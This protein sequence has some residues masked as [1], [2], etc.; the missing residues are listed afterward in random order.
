[1]PRSATPTPER[2]EV[3]VNETL[4]A[5]DMAAVAQLSALQAGYAEDRDLVNQLLGQAQMAD[6]FAK[7]SLTVSTSK[8]AH[9]KENKLYRAMKGQKS[10]DG[11]QILSGTWEEFCNLLGRSHQQVDEDLRNLKALGETAL[12]SMSRMGI[13]YRELRQYRKLPEDQKQAL[14]EVAKTGDKEGFVELAEEIIAK[15]A[16][17]KEAL[18]QK[19]DESKKE[20]EATEKRLDV[21]RKQKEEAE[22]LAARIAVMAPDEALADLQAAATRIAA[23]ALG[24]IQGGVR[25][26]LNKLHELPEGVLQPAFAAGLVGQLQAELNRLRSDFGLPDVAGAE[27]SQLAAEVSEWA[28]AK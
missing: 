3:A 15:H 8:L 22:A 9:V 7:F 24:A 26:A 20:Q 27:A 19:L 18:A 12:E 28:A 1:M 21:V 2:R 4:V 17:E 6:A 13:G 5:Q 25:Q 16:K 10:A 23:D 14:I 11:Q